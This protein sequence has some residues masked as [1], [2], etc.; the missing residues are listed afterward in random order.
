MRLNIFSIIILTV[1]LAGCNGTESPELEFE[2]APPEA[3]DT[4]ALAPEQLG[5]WD[6][7]QQHCGN[8]YEG[9]VADA[10]P[11]YSGILEADRVRIHVRDCTDRL[12]HISLHVDDNHSR[13]LLLT[14]T[15]TSLRLKH[16]HRYEDGTEEEITQYG[17]DAPGPGLETRQIFMADEHT[18]SILPDRFDNFWFLD[19][20]DESTFAYGVHWPKHGNS[21]RIEFDI[22]ATIEAPPVPWGY[23][24]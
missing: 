17:G 3:G 22:T 1:L 15:A 16:D 14:K 7:L 11:F 2:H 4:L 24:D 10:T 13:N 21:I 6:R 20:M 9:K 12:T 23:R 18:A 8:A 5:F 19:F